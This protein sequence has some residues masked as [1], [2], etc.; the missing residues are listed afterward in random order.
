[1]SRGGGRSVGVGGVARKAELLE[2]N[3]SINVEIHYFLL[4]RREKRNSNKDIPRAAQVEIMR[5]LYGR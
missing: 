1:M 4:L 5:R 3:S 2:K